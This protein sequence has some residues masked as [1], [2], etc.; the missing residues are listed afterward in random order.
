MNIGITGRPGSGK[1][2]LS[3][4]LYQLLPNSYMPDVD[5]LY[6]LKA[7]DKMMDGIGWR[8]VTA[9]VNKEEA[10]K[11]YAYIIENCKEK[12][13]EIKG[14]FSLKEKASYSLSNL[15]FKYT[16]EYIDREIPNNCDFIILDFYLLPYLK[17][18]C[19]LDYSVFLD[20]DDSIRFN[21][22]L[23][24]M[25]KNEGKQFSGNEKLERIKKMKEFEDKENVNYQLIN[26]D[27]VLKN[28][29]SLLILQEEAKRLALQILGNYSKEE[30]QNMLL[31]EYEYGKE[32]IIDSCDTTT[33]KRH[34]YEGLEKYFGSIAVNK[35]MF[36]Y[37]ESLIDNVMF[38]SFLEKKIYAIK[39]YLNTA[40]RTLRIEEKAKELSLNLKEDIASFY[41]NHLIDKD[42]YNNL[43]KECKTLNKTNR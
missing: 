18:Y 43:M 25:S 31:R 3:Y 37:E 39:Y 8:Y 17:K 5:M 12:G 33:Y 22:A 32:Q 30:I 16:K 21:H 24:R 36:L 9:G 28:P 23:E 34:A 27:L 1:T 20:V 35:L 38:K 13:I 41:K 40:K 2:T 42:T 14:D 15:T 11:A 6:H 26:Y 19:D 4:Y 10:D 29:S 7:H